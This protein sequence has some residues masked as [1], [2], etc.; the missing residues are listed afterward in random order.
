LRLKNLSFL[1]VSVISVGF[2]VLGFIPG[3]LPFR[4]NKLFCF[5]FASLFFVTLFLVKNVWVKAFCL[6][7]LLRVFVDPDKV[8]ML[9]LYTLFIGVAFYQVLSDNLNEKRVKTVLNLIVAMAIVQTIMSVLQWL[10]VWVCIMPKE[11]YKYQFITFFD[12]TDFPIRFF[13]DPALFRA[14]LPGFFD[15]IN[16]SSAFLAACLPA[17]LRRGYVWL[18]PIPLLGLLINHSFGGVFAAFICLASFAVFRFGINGVALVFVSVAVFAGYCLAF[19]NIPH[20]LFE[21]DRWQVWRHMI[22][23]IIPVHWVAGF[24]LGREVTLWPDIS[25]HTGLR[26]IWFNSHNEFITLAVELGMVGLAI[27]A[28]YLVTT[29]RWIKKH[30]DGL[31]ILLGIITVLAC[32]LTTFAVHSPIGMMFLVYMALAQRSMDEFKV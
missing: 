28:G 5:E 22:T 7:A 3:L 13:L 25:V 27:A 18:L 16:I 17:F 20:L 24:G 10:G 2:G 29:F 23:G 9:S 15:N 6:W 30:G 4:V 1:L 19:E 12:K 26:R 8:Q 14:D 11:Y 21:A 31:I 32:C